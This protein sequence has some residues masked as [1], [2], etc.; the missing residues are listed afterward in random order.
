MDPTYS[1][2]LTFNDVR[3]IGDGLNRPESVQVL[4]DGRLAVSH[5]GRCGRRRAEYAA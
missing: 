5:R 1:P 2:E 3:P 4:G